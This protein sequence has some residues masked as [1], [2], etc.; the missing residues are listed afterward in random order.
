MPALHQDA[1][2]TDVV[3]V[4]ESGS[5]QSFEDVLS[6]ARNLGLHV[7]EVRKDDYVIEGTVDSSKLVDLDKLPGVEYVRS[8]FTYVA[9]YPPG[10]PR[11]LDK[12]HR[13]VHS[14]L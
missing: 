5:E 9:D 10:D 3:V 11:D 14:E 6:K 13:E 4:V 7:R 8:V 2:V 1:Y 12:V